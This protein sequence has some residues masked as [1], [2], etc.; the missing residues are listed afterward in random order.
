MPRTTRKL[1]A[2][3]LLFVYASAV[4]AQAPT[5]TATQAAPRATPTSAPAQTQTPLPAVDVTAADMQAFIKQLPRD[6]ISDLP[7]RIVNVGG[8]RVGIYGVFRP[9]ASRQDAILHETTTS[10]VYY[11]LEGAGTLVTG[12]TLVDTRREPATSTSVRG[13]RIEGGVTRRVTK[14]DVIIIPGRT[15]HWWS[16]LEGDI[17]YMIVR[18][19]PQGRLPLK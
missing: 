4:H 6:A 13:S 9:K 1:I 2:G 17:S 16:N 14:G 3:L 10:E 18:S 5:S 19:D 12:G 8:S 11:M 15:P 7:I